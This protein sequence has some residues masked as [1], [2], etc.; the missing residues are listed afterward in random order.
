MKEIYAI[1]VEIT[2][3]NGRR[4]AAVSKLAFENLQDAKDYISA[5]ADRIEADGWYGCQDLIDNDNKM[6]YYIEALELQ[7]QT[8]SLV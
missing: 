3:P 1:R 5:R 8:Y 7:A 4:D 6:E 2:G